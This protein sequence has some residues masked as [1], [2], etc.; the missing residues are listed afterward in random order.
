MLRSSV[1]GAGR[2]LGSGEAVGREVVV[3]R[4]GTVA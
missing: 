4:S 2:P 1:V 3:L